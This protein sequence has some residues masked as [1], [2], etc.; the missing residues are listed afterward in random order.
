MSILGRDINQTHAQPLFPWI[1][2]GLEKAQVTKIHNGA[3][4]TED[5]ITDPVG[6]TSHVIKKPGKFP[7]G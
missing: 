2:S 4:S 3:W 1:F 6:F 5:S 7:S